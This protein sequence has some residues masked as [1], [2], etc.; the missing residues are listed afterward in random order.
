MAGAREVDLDPDKMVG[1]TLPLGRSSQGFFNQSKTTLEQ[2]KHNI[3][4]LLLT[5]SGERPGEPE[6]GSRLREI[7]F[8]PMDDDIAEKIEEEI[9]SVMER[10]LPYITIGSIDVNF[11][12]R[13]ENTVDVSMTVSVNYDPERFEEVNISLSG[14][15]TAAGTTG[16]TTGGGATIH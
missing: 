4:N 7:V 6:L 5:Y 1:L 14:V 16:G 12:D 9:N 13:L 8:E 10:W 2:V 11:S 15:G 3:V